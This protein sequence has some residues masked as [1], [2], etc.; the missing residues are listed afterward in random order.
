MNLA[1]KVP[2]SPILAPPGPVG[3][4]VINMHLVP[5]KHDIPNPGFQ[6]TVNGKV[7]LISQDG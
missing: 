3:P 5:T 1:Y 7:T 4:D 2:A 6:P